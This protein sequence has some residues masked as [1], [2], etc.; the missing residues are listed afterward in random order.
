MI[1]NDSADEKYKQ[2][3]GEYGRIAADKA[4]NPQAKPTGMSHLMS[5][6]EMGITKAYGH[7]AVSVLLLGETPRRLGPQGVSA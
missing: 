5:K 2:K 1:R 7:L 6:H 4:P 3:A